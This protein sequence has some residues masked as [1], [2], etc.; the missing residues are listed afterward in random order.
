MHRL[1]VAFVLLSACNGDDKNQNPSGDDTAAVAWECVLPA[2]SVD[3]EFAQQIGCQADFDFLAAD[4]FDASIPGAHSAKT[5]IDRLDDNALFFQNSDLYPIHWNFCSTHLSGDGLPMVGE[6]SSFNTTEYYSPDRRFILGA[7]TYYDEPGVW[8][9]EISPYDTADVDM[10]TTAFRLIRDNAFF[11]PDLFFHP[12]ST[13]IEKLIPSLP[14]DVKIMTTDELY[15]G[16]DYQP[17][18]L[19][20][21]TGLLT[22]H[23]REEVDGQYTPYRELVVLDA[24]PNDISIVAGIITAEFQTPLA[25]INVLSANRGTPNMGLRDAQTND[26]LTA[27][28]GKWVELTVAPFEW[29]IREITA[30][31]A[32]A[33][34]EKH[35]PDPIDVPPMDT[36]VT[37]MSDLIEVLDLDKDSLSTAIHNAIPAFGAKGTNYAALEEAELAGLPIPI[38]S[39]FGIP[40]YYYDTFMTENGLYDRIHTLMKETKWADPSWR[41]IALEEF[42]DEIRAGV[43]DPTFA[44]A[45]KAK[46]A[47]LWPGESMRFRSSTNSEDLGDFTGAGLYDSETGDP[48]VKADADDSV[49][50]AMK[51][52]FAAVWNPRAY[53][54]RD[55][56]SMDHFAV[57]MALL[58][59]PNFPD[60]EANGV[61]ITNNIFDTSGL[62][63]AFYV[64]AQEGETGVVLPDEGILPDAYLQYFYYENQPV[65]Y[66]QHSTEVPEGDTVLTNDEVYTLGVALDAINTWFLDVYGSDGGWYG[67]DVEWK[68]DDKYTPGT[69]MLFIKQ[70]RPYPAPDFGAGG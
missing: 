40:M 49:E 56:Y 34:W 13:R 60:E 18:N 68:Y 24:V 38:Q 15:A 29:T 2:D 59:T 10:I 41:M 33:W 65:V 9:Y 32:A 42:Q 64:N 23:T 58:V 7:V 17:L 3:P 28:E 54:E 46:G 19:G 45:V 6:L 44:A 37:E 25:H 26:Q 50:W 70:A 55:F 47:K 30:E 35:R 5:V 51:K 16:I 31:E 12:T 11:G 8:V 21:S 57:G 43:V 22:F 27:L 14:E 52:V 48:D 1:I 62:E 53:E 66:I 36:S 61:A 39:G 4:P 20:T 69:P 63:P 67:M